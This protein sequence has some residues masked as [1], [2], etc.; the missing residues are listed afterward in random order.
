MIINGL[1]KLSLVDY[2]SKLA[3]TIFTAGCNLRCPFCH[4]ASLVTH[5]QDSENYSE[6]EVI[7]FL[8]KRVGKL[9]GVCIT[10]GEPLLHNDISN[11]IK[12]VRELGFLI[13]LDT[14]GYFTEHLKSLLDEGLLDYVAMDIKNCPVKYP[15]TVGIPNF[16]STPVFESADILING[17]IPYEFRT[18]LVKELHTEEDM[19]RIGQKLK[20]A[21]TYYLQSFEDSGDLVGLGK[22]SDIPTLSTLSRDKTDSYRDILSQYIEYVEV[23]R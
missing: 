9:D 14:N 10:G 17:N 6:D 21:K 16:D 1:Q 4:N 7:D 5:I 20:G 8:K 22:N 2:P 11:F 13:K 23:R 19:H 3:A 12:K 18:T 15:L